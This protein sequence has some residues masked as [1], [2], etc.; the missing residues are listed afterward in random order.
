MIAQLQAIACLLASEPIPSDEFA[1]YL[2][3]VTQSSGDLIIVQPYDSQLPPL[4]IQV[5]RKIDEKTNQPL[6]IPKFVNL[7][8][9]EPI[10]VSRLVQA[11]GMYKPV[12]AHVPG[13]PPIVSK[14]GVNSLIFYI[15]VP[16][17]SQQIKMSAS[18]KDNRAINIFLER[19]KNRDI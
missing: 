14:N 13:K 17:H 4:A 11:F 18:V 15:K 9:T 6:I 1:K 8:L 3:V 7:D 5:S 19:R 12:R 16:G 2:G 10:P